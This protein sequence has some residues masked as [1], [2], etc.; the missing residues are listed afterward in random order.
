MNKTVNKKQYVR[1]CVENI[2]TLVPNAKNYHVP[3]DMNSADLLTRGITAKKIKIKRLVA[4]SGVVSKS[5]G[6]IAINNS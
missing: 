5:T 3:G 4:L 2:N 6:T 1:Q